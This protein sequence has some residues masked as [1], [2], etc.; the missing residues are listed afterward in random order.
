ML[1][2]KVEGIEYRFFNHLYAVSRCG[3]VLRK[4]LPFTPKVRRDGYLCAGRMNLFH[5]MV[6]ICWLEKPP[7]SNHVHHKDGDKTNNRASNLEWVTPKEHM[8]ERHISTVGRYTRTDSTIQKLRKAR[9]GTRDSEETRNRK[10]DILRRVSVRKNAC[11]I[12]GVVY[13]SF[14]NASKALNIHFHTIRY[15]CLSKNFPNYQLVTSS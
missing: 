6:A 10:A 9:L 14:L 7:E 11:Q 3:K 4:L 5:R 15:R 8:G 2:I 12:D 13:R 1:S